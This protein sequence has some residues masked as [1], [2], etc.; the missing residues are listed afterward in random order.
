M[1][2]HRRTFIACAVGLLLAA[3]APAAAS[4]APPPLPGTMAALGDSHSQAFNIDVGLYGK[5]PSHSWTTGYDG[6]DV[7]RSHYERILSANPAIAGRNYNYSLPRKKMSATLGQA[8]NAIAVSAEYVTILAG[9]NDLCTPTAATMTPTS[10]F[11][12]QF[13]QTMDT[14]E[15]GTS[16]QVLVFV[17]SIPNLYAIWS[18]M[19][20]RPYP[21]DPS[22]TNEQYWYQTGTCQ[23]MLSPFNTEADRQGVLT[24]EVRYDTVLRQ[25]CGAYVNCRYDGD[26]TFNAP[27]DPSDLTRV[28]SFH[29][30]FS[31]QAQLAVRSWAASFWPSSP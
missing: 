11:R 27:L 22:I 30:S 24:Q 12:S 16:R 26:A 9:T 4:N 21:L 29:M 19:H 18:V 13:K 2:R 20:L 7:V 1:A 23:S 5:N 28:D 14:L 25:V 10:T 31:G 3:A 17:S 8:Q 15:S 6:A